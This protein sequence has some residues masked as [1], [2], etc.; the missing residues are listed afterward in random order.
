MTRAFLLS[1]VTR[2]VLLSPREKVAASYRHSWLVWEPGAWVAPPPGLHMTLVPAP[3]QEAMR[4]VQGD[5]LCFELAL[6]EGQTGL[7]LGR[8]ADCDLVINDGTVSRSHLWLTREPEDWAAQVLPSSRGA[9]SDGRVLSPGTRLPLRRGT[10]L[11][12]GDVVL[13]YYD[14]QGLLLRAAEQGARAIR[15]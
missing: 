3:P 9:T 12:L 2:Q 4:P 13:T 1:F 5:A 11:Q 15:H 10:R 6:T 7:R 8:A 14:P